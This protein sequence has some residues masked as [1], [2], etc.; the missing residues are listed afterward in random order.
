MKKKHTLKEWFGATRYWSF[1]VSA[2]PVLAT[3]A[4]LFQRGI[5]PAGGRT[6]LFL[7]LC[8][9]G[10]VILHS[11][12]NV[13]SDW[14]DY[15]KGVDNEK[16]Y[17]V[18]NL[19]MHR[20]EPEEFL[21]FS[22][23]LF[24]VGSAIGIVLVVLCGLQVLWIGL[25]G[26]V[27]TAS[28][29]FLKYRA[30]GDLDIFL[31][32]GVLTVLGTSYVLCGSWQW[33][34]LI[35]SVPIGIITVSVLHANNTIDSETDREAGI[36]T[37]AMLL[38]AKASVA[39][40]QC[41]MVIPFLFVAVSVAVGYLHPLSLLCLVAALPAFANIRHARRFY[42]EGLSSLHGLDQET[43]KLQLI[44]SGLLSL[45]LFLGGLL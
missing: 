15:R 40:Y 35:L 17:A 41:Y 8:L 10:V 16:A 25:A 5:L 24:C 21:R 19:V 42:R 30:L 12:G 23:L 37:F 44:F 33:H 43:A 45:G 20:F 14:F 34:S 11:A 36:R 13:L 3:G 2:M 22:A 29:S 1:P 32:F 39:L 4:Y 7:L 6:V 28:Y 38:G 27:L 31:I 26:V 9:C 18:D